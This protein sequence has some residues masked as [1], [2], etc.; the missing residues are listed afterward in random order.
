M[1]SPIPAASPPSVIMLNVRPATF[2]TMNVIA[3]V[4]GTTMAAT[5]ALSGLIVK[6][7]TTSTASARPSTIASRT[8]LSDSATSVRLIVR[9]RKLNVGIALAKLRQYLPRLG[10][11]RLSAAAR[12]PRDSHQHR[13]PVLGRR[14]NVVFLDPK[15]DR[16]HVADAHRLAAGR[17]RAAPRQS[18][19]LRCKSVVTTVSSIRCDSFIRPADA[20]TLFFASPATTS[21]G[22]RSC[23]SIRAGSSRTTNSRY[24]PPITPT[25]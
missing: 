4:H 3:T 7:S 23:C 25:R 17:R 8:L 14:A 2:I 16:S 24:L 15:F 12:P 19:R 11:D 5:S 6:A 13:R 10:R 1:K 22:D 21:P 9:N 20:T 18:D